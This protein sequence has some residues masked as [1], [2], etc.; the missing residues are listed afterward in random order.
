MYRKA[1]AR[2]KINSSQA[3]GVFKCQKGV[4]QGCNLSPLLFNLFI[5]GLEVE[6]AESGRCPLEET[7]LDA[8]MFADDIIL[9]LVSA[10]GL[11][12]ILAPLKS[13]A[14]NGT[15]VLTLKSLESVHLG[16]EN[17]TILHLRKYTFRM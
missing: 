8:L 13:F 11:K 5:S 12:N 16:Q 6:L 3:T 9:L 4:R 1:T 10:D 17:I 14:V 2:V 7:T 15:S